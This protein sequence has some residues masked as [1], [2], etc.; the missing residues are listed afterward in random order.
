MTKIIEIAKSERMIKRYKSFAWS[1]GAMIA[2]G[3]MDFCIDILTAWNPDN[4]ITLC[5]GLIFS[6]ITKYLNNKT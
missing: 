5:A 6:Q 2:A 1:V 3:V 4:L